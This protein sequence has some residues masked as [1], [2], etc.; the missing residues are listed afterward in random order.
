MS[1]FEQ[2]YFQKFKF[3]PAQISRYIESAV[4]DLNIAQKDQFIEVKFTYCY[5][6]LIKIGMAV[7]AQKGGVKVRSVM[8]HHIKI[9]N[10]LSEILDNP[11]ILTVGNVPHIFDPFFS[12]KANGTGLG[13][14]IT[15]GIVQEHGGRIKVESTVGK[16][17]NFMIKLPMEITDV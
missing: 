8:G 14:S 15:Q 17:T 4:R 11:D 7:L 3:T 5:Q 1:S 13:L 10:K 9:L 2:E 6:A 12:K 16:G